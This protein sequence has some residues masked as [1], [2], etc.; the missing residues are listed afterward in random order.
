MRPAPSSTGTGP[1][2]GSTG[3]GPA[4]S[5]TG[6]GPAGRSADPI[7]VRPRRG[8]TGTTTPRP[9]GARP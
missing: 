2:P 6:T 8:S 9:E 3:T 4:P 5:S 7:P 1:A